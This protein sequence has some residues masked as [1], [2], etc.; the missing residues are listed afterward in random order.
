MS[1][2]PSER[3]LAYLDE[4]SRSDT[5][6][7][8]LGAYPAELLERCVTDADAAALFRGVAQGIITWRP[9]GRFDTLDRPLPPRGCW[10][11]IEKDGTCRRPC[12]EFIPQLAAY[13][14]LISALGYH[15]HR[16]LFDTPQVALQLDLAVLDDVSRVVVLGEVKK[17]SRD[18]N[19]LETG[20]LTHR[21]EQPEPKRGDEP[22][23]LAWRLW[24]TRAPYLWLIGPSDLRAYEVQHDPLRLR[25]I[26]HLPRGSALGLDDGPSAM[27]TPPDLRT[28]AD[29]G[30]DPS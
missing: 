24:L 10:W 3:L 29:G 4:Q 9:G 26:D 17:E 6:S 22:R 19:R 13:V 11:L 14:E 23:Q 21:G 30:S 28:P 8:P 27:M 1:E 12:L 25:R 7:L 15:R 2:V 20:L 5:P 16:V 18:L